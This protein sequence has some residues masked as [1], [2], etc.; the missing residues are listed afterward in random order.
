MLD[1]LNEF[2][3]KSFSQ[4]TEKKPKVIKTY[5]L[6]AKFISTTLRMKSYKPA[7]VKS[8][9]NEGSICIKDSKKIPEVFNILIFL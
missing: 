8:I 5:K 7:K 4:S 2:I 1:E 3:K 9:I 6:I